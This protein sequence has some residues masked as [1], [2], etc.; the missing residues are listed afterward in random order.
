MD[1]LKLVAVLISEFGC[2]PSVKGFNGRTPLHQACKSGHLDVVEKLVSEYGCDVND[3][4]SDGALHLFILLLGL[5][6]RE[7]VV[8]ELI[9]KYKCPVDC[10]DPDGY[11]PLHLAVT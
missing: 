2:S 4:D 7:E 9:T 1:I 3:L 5:A 10:V 6:G 8:R 11:T